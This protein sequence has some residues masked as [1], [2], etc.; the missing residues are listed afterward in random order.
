MA[1]TFCPCAI[2]TK[3]FATGP[4]AT[5]NQ[6]TKFDTLLANPFGSYADYRKTYRQISIP[7]LWTRDVPKRVEMQNIDFFVPM[8]YFL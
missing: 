6:H 4:I 5:Y 7:L 2:L 3:T 1:V 8:Q